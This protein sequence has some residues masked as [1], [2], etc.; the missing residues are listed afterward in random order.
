MANTNDP[1]TRI[2]RRQRQLA[3]IRANGGYYVTDCHPWSIKEGCQRFDCPM[4][5]LAITPEA[6]PTDHL[7]ECT[8]V[9]DLADLLILIQRTT[10]LPEPA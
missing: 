9:G 8:P 2:G 3:Q 7:L 1:M 10:P 6:K 5:Q 4:R